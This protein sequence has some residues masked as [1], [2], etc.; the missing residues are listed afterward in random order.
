VRENLGF[1]FAAWA[2]GLTLCAAP[3]LTRLYLVNDSIVGPLDCGAFAA[4]VERVRKSSAD[5]VGLTENTRP[6]PHLQ[7]FFSS[8]SAHARWPLPTKEQVIDVY[9]TRLTERLRRAGLATEALFPS[10]QA[11]EHALAACGYTCAIIADA[12]TA[13]RRSPAVSMTTR[14]LDLGCGAVPRNPYAREEVHMVDLVAPPGVDAARFRCANLS[15]QPIPHPDSSFDSISAYDFLE[16]VPRILPTPDGL[17]TRFPFIELMDEI[18]RVLRPD[19]RFYALTPC[20]PRAEA[21]QDPTHVNFITHKTHEYFCENPPKGRMYGFRGRFQ[22][23]RVHW[24][25]LPQDFMAE[26]GRISLREALKRRRRI[27]K[28]KTS[29]LLWEFGAVKSADTGA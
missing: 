20:Y 21:F 10:I 23:L 15:L 27:F 11:D 4:L 18:W 22:A 6:L 19:G 14:H 7:R 17:A 13:A 1:D 26:R 16:H 2:H 25:L 12:H 24:A 8:S 9:E 3:G 29:H 28:G 5:V